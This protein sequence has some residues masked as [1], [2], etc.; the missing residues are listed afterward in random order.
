MVAGR[1]AKAIPSEFLV[2]VFLRFGVDCVCTAAAFAVVEQSFCICVYCKVLCALM[3]S[4]CWKFL[5]DSNE[6]STWHA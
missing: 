6:T 5:K 2:D 3:L 1:N 4:V